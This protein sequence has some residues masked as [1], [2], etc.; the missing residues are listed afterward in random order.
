MRTTRGFA[1]AIRSATTRRR[2]RVLE[3]VRTVAATARP[4]S[5][6]G[7]AS[8]V[9]AAPTGGV[10]SAPVRGPRG[11]RPPARAAPRRAGRAR[12]SPQDEAPDEAVDDRQDQ[13]RRLAAGDPERREPRDVG[14]DPEQE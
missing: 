6:E 11:V 8:E 5:T 3:P 7:G 2:S 12:L 13:H 1:R 4:P 14:P 10:M 9:R